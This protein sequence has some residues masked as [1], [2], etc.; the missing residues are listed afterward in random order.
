MPAYDP[1]TA[2]IVVDVQNDFAHPDG[3]LFVQG[4]AG[5][6]ARVND[7]IRRATESGALVVY[8]QDWHPPS[9]PHFEND[10]GLWPVHCVRDTWGAQFHS[11]LTADAGP[12]VRK[13]VDGNDG[14][15]GFTTRDP[16]T[17][18]QHP[19]ELEDLLLEAEVERCVV[20]GL[21]TD[22]CVKETVLDACRLGFEVLV[23]RTGVAAVNMQPGD[24]DAA[25]QAM[26]ESGALIE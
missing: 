10:G 21:A 14:Y 19:T 16:Q 11:D 22:Y 23:P 18:D 12:N 20:V 2:L 4:A 13:G 5:V 17:G 25:L 24:G 15:S 9:T 7:E 1:Q 26:A 6:V 3:S 8:T